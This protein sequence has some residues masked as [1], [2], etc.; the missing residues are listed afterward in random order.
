MSNNDSTLPPDSVAW[1][2]MA[3]GDSR[4]PRH[5]IP[6]GD[7]LIGSGPECCL[8]LGDGVLPP[9]HSVIRITPTSAT[10]TTMVRTPELVVNGE[11]TRH[12][13]LHDGDMVEVGPFRMTFRL[14]ESRAAADLNALTQMCQVEIAEAE[15]SGDLRAELLLDAIQRELSVI[16]TLDRSMRTGVSELLSAAIR[17]DSEENGVES[18]GVRATDSIMDQLQLQ[19]DKLDNLGQILEHVVKQQ[20][21]MTDI[22]HRLTEQVARLSQQNARYR[23]AG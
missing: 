21:V 11:A 9:L 16:E 15:N 8:R 3:M 20:R 2:Q 13:D 5:A 10:W 4:F 22:I 14:C 12:A 7:F 6:M 17:A 23:R 19:N 1:L 18:T